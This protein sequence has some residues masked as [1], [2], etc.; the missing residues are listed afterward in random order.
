ML[1]DLRRRVFDHAQRLSLAFH[2]R[3]TS[4]R[5]VSRL[6]SDVDALN[7]L[8]DEGLEVRGVVDH[9]G[10]WSSVYF[11]DPNGVRLEL[12]YQH[13]PLGESDAAVLGLNAVSDGRHVVLSKH[14]A[15]YAED[16]RAR[17]TVPDL[18]ALCACAPHLLPEV[19]DRLSKL[20]ALDVKAI[21]PGHGE[22]L[23]VNASAELRRLAGA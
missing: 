15:Q 22:P 20:A 6:T 1:L 14:A 16:L 10:T 21:L 7:E 19:R 23:T 17:G 4:G 3:Y 18:T 8:L 13:R 2:E 9:E 5:V 11:F 12:T